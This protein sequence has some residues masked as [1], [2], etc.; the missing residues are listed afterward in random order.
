MKNS[1]TSLVNTSVEKQLSNNAQRAE[2]KAQSAHRD[3]TEGREAKRQRDEGRNIVTEWKRIMSGSPILL[4]TIIFVFCA[5]A[6]IV[7]SWEMYREFLGAFFGMPHWT[8]T[9]L[10]GLVIVLGAAYVSHFLSKSLSSNLFDLEVFNYRN[11]SKKGNILEEEAI[12]HVR[13]EKK[14]DLAI[15]LISGGILLMVVAFISWHRSILMLDATGSND[16]SLIQ[17]I[18][19]VIIVLFEILTGIYLGLYLLPRWRIEMK[20]HKENKSFKR[21]LWACSETDRLVK[22]L[23]DS[24]LLNNEYF[25]P[26]KNALSSYYRAQSRTTDENYLDITSV[27]QLEV[28]TVDATGV[29]K[30][31]IRILGVTNNGQVIASGI[32]NEGGYLI[33]Y[34]D[35]NNDQIEL[36]INDFSTKKGPYQANTSH[37]VCIDEE[38]HRLSS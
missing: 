4:L 8:I 16:Y 28:T 15:G 22:A 38:Q 5:C 17:K 30:S 19:P 29:P 26:S 14:R 34:W 11:I 6:E 18:L 10:L 9:L 33:L 3:A 21:H 32:S 23:M 2:G 7:Y 24:A 13:S 31:N 36:M 1:T 27:K 12:D 20:I 25:K 37:V 35:S